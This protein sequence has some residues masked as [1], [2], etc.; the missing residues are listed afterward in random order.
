MHFS[1]AP[2][3]WPQT[4]ASVFFHE[5]EGFEAL[6]APCFPSLFKAT[7]NPSPALASF[8]GLTHSCTGTTSP[9]LLRVA[10]RSRHICSRPWDGPRLRWPPSPSTFTKS[11]SESSLLAAPLSGYDGQTQQH[12]DGETLHS[13][14]SLHE[15]TP[16]VGFRVSPRQMSFIRGRGF[17]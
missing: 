17:I 7:D 10:G 14:L 16:A 3:I 13:Q 2:L 4:A 9:S 8:L 15:R 5:L 6:P 11:T 1:F 12:E